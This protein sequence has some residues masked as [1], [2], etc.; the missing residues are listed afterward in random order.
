MLNKSLSY[1]KVKGADVCTIRPVSTVTTEQLRVTRSSGQAARAFP[2]VTMVPSLCILQGIFENSIKM[3]QAPS[4]F[5][6]FKVKCR[7]FDALKQK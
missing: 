3:V 1:D 2:M 6:N 4:F 7:R 5:C